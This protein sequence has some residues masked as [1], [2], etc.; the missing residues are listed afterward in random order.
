MNCEI[1][2]FRFLFGTDGPSHG[3]FLAKSQAK[4]CLDSQIRVVSDYVLPLLLLL[5]VLLP[6]PLFYNDFADY[7]D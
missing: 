5:P 1:L 4:Y 2:M 6:A 3:C 7:S